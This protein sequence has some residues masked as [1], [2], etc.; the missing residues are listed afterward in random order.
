[1]DVTS[2]RLAEDDAAE[3]IGETLPRLLQVLQE[4]DVRELELHEGDVRVRLHR[5]PGPE[6]ESL[7]EVIAEAEALPPPEP[8][9]M[10]IRS[11]LVGTFYRAAKPGMPPLVA[12]G[13]D[14]EQ[15][16]V[17]G[18]VEALSVLTDVEAGCE[19]TVTK[20]LATDGQ[21]VEYGQALFE[22]SLS[23]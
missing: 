10:E 20:V 16:T 6:V 23:G 17:V 1:M 21:P 4:S 11:P 13:S 15:D 19:G 12:E 14:V 8:P 5:L 3:Y 7:A 9:T 22:V 2:S 18:I